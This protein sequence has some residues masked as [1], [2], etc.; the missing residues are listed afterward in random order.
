[1]APSSTERWDVV[2]ADVVAEHG[3]GVGVL[4][5]NGGAGEADKGSLRQGVAQ[6]PGEAVDEKSY[7]LRWASSAITT[8][9]GRGESTGCA[10]PFSSGKNFWMV[11]KTTPP[12]STESLLRRSARLSA[13]TGD[14]RSKSW[15]R[16]KVLKSWSSKSLRVGQHDDGGV[17]HS[18]L[19]NDSPSVK[20]HGQALPRPLGMPDDANAPIA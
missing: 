1:M 11:V 12:D 8:M 17:A 6:M 5:L 18:W 14:W 9:L 19:A 4:P 16:E 10:S 7:W 2:D 15:Q 20:S 13:C 3:A